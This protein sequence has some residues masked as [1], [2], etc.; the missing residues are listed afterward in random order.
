V[1]NPKAGQG[2]GEGLTAVLLEEVWAWAA[3]PAAGENF[4]EVGP[5]GKPTAAMTLRL[6]AH[7]SAWRS[8]H[9]CSNRNC[10][11]IL[12]MVLFATAP[13]GMSFKGFKESKPAVCI[14]H[15]ME[16]YQYGSKRTQAQDLD[17]IP[18]SA[19]WRRTVAGGYRPCDFSYRKS[20]KW[21][22][23]VCRWL[24]PGKL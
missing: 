15:P 13:S 2:E 12:R 8:R 11:N 1:A 22:S 18:W 24:P 16:C 21:L 10:T 14:L 9:S 7:L 5:K 17:E 6:H 4:G 19:K 23:A 3:Q 20:S